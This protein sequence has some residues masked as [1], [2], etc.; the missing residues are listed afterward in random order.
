ML[1]LA[2]AVLPLPACQTTA[3]LTPNESDRNTTRAELLTREAV[4]Q[5]DR[6]PKAAEETLRQALA[7]DVF[8]GPAYN[9]LGVLYLKQNKFYEAATEFES[10]RRLMPGHPDPRMNLAITLERAGRIDDAL[11]SYD[12]ALE[13]NPDHI[14]TMQA[15]TRLQIRAGRTDTRT[16][17]FLSDIALRGETPLW[18]EWAKGQISKREP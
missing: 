4:E 15:L 8:H 14:P 7:A 1:L 13:V 2:C 3:N 18:R 16:F 9:N 17:K 12:E 11:K 5:L 6:N 10:A